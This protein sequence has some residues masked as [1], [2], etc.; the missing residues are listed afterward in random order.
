MSIKGLFAYF[1]RVIVVPSLLYIAFTFLPL[2]AKSQKMTVLTLESSKVEAAVVSDSAKR[3]LIQ[4]Y[5]GKQD[6]AMRKQ[7]TAR[8]FNLSNNHVLVEFYDGQALL[9]NNSADFEKLKNIRFI[10]TDIDF[11]KKSISYKIEITY[12]KGQELIK[13]I[14]PKR[15]GQFKSGLPDFSNI[16]VYELPNGQILFLSTTAKNQSA[17]IYENIKALASECNDVLNQEFGDMEVA[18]KKFINGDPLL[19]YETE[20]QLVYP[21]DMKMI[22]QN[23]K[24]SL[25]ETKIYVEQYYGN[26]YW[27]E[28]GYYVLIDDINQKN[29]AGSK[30]QILTAR[31][32]EKLEDV[33]KAQLRY[34]NLKQREPHSEHF[35]KQI[36]DKYGKAF[37]DNIPQLIENLPHVLNFDKERLSLDS[38]GMEIVDEAI[39]WIAGDYKLFDTWFPNVLAYYGQCYILNK[40]DGS[41]VVKKERDYDVWVPHLILKDTED[42]FDPRDFYKSLFEGPVPLKSAGDWDGVIRKMRTNK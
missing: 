15:L 24:L 31:V 28:K 18:S 41:W 5:N 10:K 37:T 6:N 26:L 17:A 23:H 19:D 12:D 38:A 32:Y 9:I 20:G 36:S 16:A 11:L 13:L 39:H 8:T 21:K 27:S 29:G 14:N 7:W 42:A 30:M 25:R 4:E 33:R 1:M 2:Y 34:E 40:H 3:K 22:I 35:Y